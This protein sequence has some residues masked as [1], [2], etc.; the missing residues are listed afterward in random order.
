MMEAERASET[1]DY[2]SVLMLLVTQEDF[3]ISFYLSLLQYFVRCRFLKVVSSVTYHP[4]R[5]GKVL[6]YRV[7]LTSRCSVTQYFEGRLGHSS[8]Y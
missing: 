1:L 5:E 4:Q 2:S 3:I 7:A 8:L 6:S